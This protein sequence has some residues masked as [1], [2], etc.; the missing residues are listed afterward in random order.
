MPTPLVATPATES[1]AQLSPDGKWLAYTSDET[2]TQHVYVRPFSSTPP[3]PETKWQIS[4]AFG[5]EPRWRAD[6]H[7]LYYLE[8]AAVATR[9]YRLT[10]VPITAGAT[11]VGTPTPL[12]DVVT[13]GTLAFFNVFV[14]A[15]APDGQQFLV[16]T[17]A[18]DAQPTLD[19]ILNWAGDER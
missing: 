19:V 3:L 7:E 8:Y 15:P 12:F 6:S 16:A 4:S 18:S 14:Y 11:P 5:R 1:Q 13:L 17:T 9:R 2:G 10:A